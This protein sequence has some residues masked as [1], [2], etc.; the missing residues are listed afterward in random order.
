MLAL[1]CEGSCSQETREHLTLPGP[2]PALSS[3]TQ[4]AIMVPTRMGTIFLTFFKAGELLMESG[5]LLALHACNCVDIWRA[6]GYIMG[7]AQ[8]AKLRVASEGVPR[9]KRK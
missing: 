5:I 7:A 1:V 3:S 2:A 4:E 9:E 8:R 6:L